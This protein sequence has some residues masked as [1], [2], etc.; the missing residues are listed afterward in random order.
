MGLLGQGLC[1][2][3]RIGSGILLSA[4]FCIFRNACSVKQEV[5]V[6]GK[7]TGVRMESSILSI[8]FSLCKDGEITP[9][10]NE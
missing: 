10:T 3:G 1:L 2:V 6:A 9:T 7:I 4:S 5:G 8:C